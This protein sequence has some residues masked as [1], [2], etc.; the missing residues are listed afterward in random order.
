MFLSAFLNAELLY[1][2]FYEETPLKYENF[3]HFLLLLRT[4]LI[5]S[6]VMSIFIVVCSAAKSEL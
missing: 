3:E 4:L 2:P 1:Y 6:S 5:H